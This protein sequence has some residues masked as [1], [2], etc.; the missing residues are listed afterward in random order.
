M[1]FAASFEEEQQYFADILIAIKQVMGAHLQDVQEKFQHRFEKLED[2][3]RSRDETI[4]QLRSHI[5]ELERAAD[6]SYAVSV[7]S[8]LWSILFY[9][10]CYFG[11]YFYL[12]LLFLFYVIFD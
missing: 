5:I 12:S 2:E 8:F 6:D 9:F 4:A 11:H 7:S 1:P 10:R 3:L